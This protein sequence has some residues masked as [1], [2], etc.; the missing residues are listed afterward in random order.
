M[1]YAVRLLTRREYSRHELRLKFE[2]KFKTEDQMLIDAVLVKLEASEYQSDWRYTEM[3]VRGRVNRGYGPR[4]IEQ[5]LSLKGISRE[6]IKETLQPFSSKWF[7]LATETLSKRYSKEQLQENRAKII[8]FLLGRGYD[9]GI[10]IKALEQSL[11]GCP[12]ESYID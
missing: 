2:Q 10:A 7:Q 6:M 4:Y 9:P 5:Y 3:V 11:K 12:Y 1:N 8:R